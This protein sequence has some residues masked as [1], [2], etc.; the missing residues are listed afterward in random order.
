MDYGAVLPPS[1][2][3]ICLTYC[4]MDLFVAFSDNLVCGV[5]T[6]AT[7]AFRTYDWKQQ[8]WKS[9]P[10]PMFIQEAH[11]ESV[12]HLSSQDC[13]QLEAKSSWHDGPLLLFG[14]LVP[15][16]S[17]HI[18][19]SISFC[20][21]DNPKLSLSQ[22]DFSW[23]SRLEI[24]FLRLPGPNTIVTS[25]LVSIIAK[26]DVEGVAVE[27]N[28]AGDQDVV[29]LDV[30]WSAEVGLVADGHCPLLLFK[31]WMVSVIFTSNSSSSTRLLYP[32]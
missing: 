15:L 6:P 12:N 29:V 28:Q 16:N 13:Q 1:L 7:P 18:V 17:E 14:K 9:T 32:G 24:D 25:W 20:V 10:C 31:S 5:W 4:R 27:L 2:M 26:F 11:L 23:S 30:N 3:V 19:F 21:R 22:L 8:L